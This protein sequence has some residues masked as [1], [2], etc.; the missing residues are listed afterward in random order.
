MKHL[1]IF[2]EFDLGREE[3]IDFFEDT[4]LVKVKDVEITSLFNIVTG[5]KGPL[6]SGT[7]HRAHYATY[8]LWGDESFMDFI[9]R[10]NETRKRIIDLQETE[11]MVVNLDFYHPSMTDAP[12]SRH[13]SFQYKEY[14]ISIIKN[15]TKRIHKGYGMDIFLYISYINWISSDSIA[16]LTL[17]I[18]NKD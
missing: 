11:V 3:I 5:R 16:K 18:L 10:T 6:G 15:Y 2:E 4:E 1:K 9:S 14:I 13:P 12:L 7:E 8:N 17:V